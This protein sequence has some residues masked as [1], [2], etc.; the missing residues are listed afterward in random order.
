MKVDDED[1]RWR[2]V[3]PTTD[4][5][6]GVVVSAKA[7]LLART[8]QEARTART[9]RARRAGRLGAVV[10]LV[11]LGATGGGVA[12]GLIPSPI[13]GGS[14]PVPT[15]TA[16]APEV[17]GST[18]TPEPS[19]TSTPDPA[20]E[21]GP[22]TPALP[23]DCAALA[24]G[25]SL[26]SLLRAPELYGT[27]DAYTP[28]RAA[29]RQSGVTSCSWGSATDAASA[30]LELTVSPD[31]SGAGAW[32]QEQ[33]ALGAV[34]TGVGDESVQRCTTEYSFCDGTVV[35][36]DWW[37]EYHYQQSPALA[38]DVESL[39]TAHA[40]RL[41][42]VVA[43]EDPGPAW[44]LPAGSERWTPTGPC[45]TLGTSVP[46]S[47]ILGSPLVP[48][49]PI[50]LLPGT[51]NGIERTQSASYQCR[52]TV[53]DGQPT[54][55]GV[56]RGMDVS[57]AAGARWAFDAAPATFRDPDL[58]SVE[59][60]AVA[61]SDAAFLRCQTAEGPSCWLDVLVDDSWLQVGYGNSTPPERSD[62]LAPVAESVIAARG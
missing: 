2:S 12:L 26:T 51:Q 48:D 40:A 33:R 15:M 6:T 3:P 8:E 50:D 5:T 58:G 32:M 37:I 53:P 38:A 62:V 35:V 43:A 55:E 4:E 36:G 18:S 42:D 60:V 29:L 46:M 57:V 13:D 49:Q 27:G 34:G 14:A 61:G 30:S 31:T 1:G 22:P 47:T 28:E 9:K 16:S 19:P 59:P 21:A 39:L 11:A 41:S 24:T 7:A 25:S 20:P 10:A 44:A 54:D 52:W 23:L 17:D 45:S 56:L